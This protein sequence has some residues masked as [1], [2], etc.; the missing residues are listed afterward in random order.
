LSPIGE[1]KR[2]R[3]DVANPEMIRIIEKRFAA[4][5]AKVSARGWRYFIGMPA[6]T[7]AGRPWNQNRFAAMRGCA[8]RARETGSPLTGTTGKTLA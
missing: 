4:R 5:A 3:R 7:E 2:N 8:S 1:I 6:S